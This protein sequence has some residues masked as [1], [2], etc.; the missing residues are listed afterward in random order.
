MRRPILPL[1]IVTATCASF[2]L[3]ASAEKE[4]LK[5]VLV[6][7]RPTPVI[8]IKSQGAEGIRYGF[9]GGRVVK[10]GGTYHL[11]TSEM[12]GDPFWVKMKLGYWTSKDR[13]NWKRVSTV[14]ESSGEYAGKDPRAALWSPLPVYEDGEDLWNLFYVAY[15][16]QP[17]TD[18]KW[19]NNYDGMIWR[20]IS[21]AKGSNGIGGPYKDAGIVMQPGPDSDSWEGLQG[22]DSFFPYRVDGKWYAFFGSANTEMKDE[23]T[24]RGPWSVG[25]GAA[26]ELAGPWKRL[27]EMNP[28]K[29]EPVF[30][31][32]PIVTKL[33]DGT[34]LAVYDCHTANAIGFTYSTDGIRWAAG[35]AVVIQPKGKGRWADDVRTPLGLVPEGDDTFTVFYTGYENVKSQ[36]PDVSEPGDAA[37]GFV[38][39][40]LSR[41][42]D[43]VTERGK[44]TETVMVSIDPGNKKR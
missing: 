32:N 6:E 7:Q 34:Y 31:E 10:I 11:F 21:A 22:T 33:E 30:I 44:A 2:F 43:L 36:F 4:N 38:T 35:Q 16:S 28:L 27:S 17:S 5:L 41:G 42:S 26:P 40:K 14:F 20:A 39:V 8:T 29:I 3:I 1:V 19:L 12:V 15:R 13:V 23:G 24:L 37:V 18:T 25:L 9:E